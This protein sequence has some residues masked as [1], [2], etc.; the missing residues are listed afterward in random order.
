MLSSRTSGRMRR[1]VFRPRRF[2]VWVLLVAGM[3]LS[4]AAQQPQHPPQQAQPAE[5]QPTFRAGINYVG[6]DVIVTGRNDAPVIDL[7][8]EDFEVFEDGKPQPIEQFRLVRINAAGNVGAPPPRR[9]QS[10]DDEVQEAGREDVRVFAILL[11][12]Y[13]T[14][15]LTA[16]SVKE[17]LTKFPQTQ[18]GP[19]D[20]VALMY[21]LTPTSE[22]L[23]TNNHAS[24]VSAVQRFEGRKFGYTPRNRFEDEYSRYPASE[25]ER[26]RNEVVMD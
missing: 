1:N 26:I 24:I 5:Q 21:P 25:V 17:P 10:R 22:I 19:N 6:V 16:L 2:L 7:K 3:S 9:V 12:D 13:H 18:L 11:D 23:F 4:S 20:L 15:K 14:R 8:R